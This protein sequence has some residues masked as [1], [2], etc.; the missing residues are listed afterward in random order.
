[1]KENV[2]MAIIMIMMDVLLPVLLRNIGLVEEFHQSVPQ[3]A[4]A[5]NGMLMLKNNVITDKL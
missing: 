2:M 1:M 4:Q 3:V 5:Q